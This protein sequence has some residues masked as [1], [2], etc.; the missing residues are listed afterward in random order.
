M[1]D[2]EHLS[3]LY[4]GVPVW[5]TWRQSDWAVAPDLSGAVLDQEDGGDVGNLC[6]LFM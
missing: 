4:Q 6:N 3:I 1:A 5:N 2:K